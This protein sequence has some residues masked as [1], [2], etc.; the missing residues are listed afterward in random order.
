MKILL[1]SVYA[2]AKIRA[3]FIPNSGQK[4]VLMPRLAVVRQIKVEAFSNINS[5]RQSY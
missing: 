1:S 5:G 3:G 4:Y 2:P